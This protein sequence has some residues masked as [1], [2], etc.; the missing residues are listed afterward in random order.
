ME[1]CNIHTRFTSLGRPHELRLI[2]ASIVNLEFAPLVVF[3]SKWGVT[4]T[5]SFIDAKLTFIIRNWHQLNMP[6]V[7]RRSY[8][9][10]A[11]VLIVLQLGFTQRKDFVVG[12]KKS[13]RNPARNVASLPTH[14][15]FDMASSSSS[16]YDR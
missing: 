5:G 11:I 7:S 12:A 13:V 6:F 2:V 3:C 8:S 15:T 9:A 4:P 1:E 14:L 16:T 10:E